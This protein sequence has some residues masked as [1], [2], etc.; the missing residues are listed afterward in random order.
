M[1]MLIPLVLLIGAVLGMRFKVLI[2][3]LAIGFALIAILA[4]G[5]VRGDSMSATLMADGLAWICLQV[6]YICGIVTR[7]YVA[8]ARAKR[9]RKVWLQAGVS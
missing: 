5:I 2:L 9:T 3:I 1:S 7:Y 6:G 8:L 4:G